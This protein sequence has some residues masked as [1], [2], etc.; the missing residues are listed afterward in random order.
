MT[1]HDTRLEIT[2]VQV[3]EAPTSLNVREKKL[4]AKI[5][6]QISGSKANK[7]MEKQ[8]PFRIKVYTVNLESGA[9]ALVASERSQLHPRGFEYTKQKEFPL[10][11]IGRHKLHAI[12]LLLPPGEMMA[13]RRGPTIKVVP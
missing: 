7:L 12:V 6:F 11:S 13:S 2:E 8:T 9:L 10:P 5:R 3:S 4:I 1:P